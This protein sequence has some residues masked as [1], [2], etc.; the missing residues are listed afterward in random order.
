M[1][2]GA[3][4]GKIPRVQ[5]KILLFGAQGLLGYELFNALGADFVVVPFSRFN[6]NLTD[7]ARIA[8]ALEEVKPDIVINAAG[9]TDTERAEDPRF[10]KEVLALNRDAPAAMAA[11]CRAAGALFVHFST[12][13]VF[14][15]T[16]P[17]YREDA[18]KNPLNFYGLS[19]AQGEDAVLAANPQSVI[20]RTAWLF[21]ENGMNFIQKVL[22]LAKKNP[23][24]QIAAD[25]FV[26]ATWARDTAFALRTLLLN[27]KFE[28]NVYHLVNEGA[29]S[30]YEIAQMVLAIKGIQ[31]AIKPVAADDFLS[32]IRRPKKALLLNTRTEKL[33]PLKEALE[34]FLGKR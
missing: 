8:I 19:K 10:Q 27:K 14:D 5:P 22:T 17:P 32:V 11:W 16:K 29:Y 34:E 20:V 13:F 7:T 28:H 12:D 26:S 25:L 1:L 21:G 33:R 30:L 18:P 23:E 3:P 9:W 4:Y 15:G 24:L 6:L 2:F 31:K